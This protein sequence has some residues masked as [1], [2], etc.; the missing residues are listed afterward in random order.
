DGFLYKLDARTGRER[1]RVRVDE[2]QIDRLPIG[3]PKSR[4]DYRA[5][6]AALQEGRL[7]IGT[8][9]GHVLALD[10]NSGRKLWD[11][12][13]A[14]SVLSTPRVASGKVYFGSFDG[15]VYALDAASGSLLWKHDT[16]GVVSSA[17]AL[18]NGRV[19]VG[20]RSYDLLALDTATG[21]PAWT[22]YFWFSW[23][24]SPATI[25]GDA[26][27]IGSSDAAKLSAFDA[28]TGRRLWEIDAGGA[29]LAQPAVTDSRVYIGTMG[30]VHY[31]VPHQAAILAAE[32]QSGR[33]V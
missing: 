1:W 11:F 29:A 23:V 33:V 5:S 4:Y 3:N 27:Y 31:L 17:P 16:G 21:K 18:H 2:K 20:S 19:I 14:D 22:R 13:A 12:A 30:T 7:Y 9:D 24:E 8:Y 28:R 25:W 26:V 32:R 6:A 15:G 10:S